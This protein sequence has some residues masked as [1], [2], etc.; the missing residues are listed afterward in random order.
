MV[1]FFETRIGQDFLNGDIPELIEQMHKISS[2][3][4][5]SNN[6]KE[7]ELEL[8]EREIKI[9]AYELGLCSKSFLKGEKIYA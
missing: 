1:H 5:R 6:L 2:Q 7:K 9:R 8:K 4:D 3:L